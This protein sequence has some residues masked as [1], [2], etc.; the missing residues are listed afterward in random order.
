MK[1][2]QSEEKLSGV[3]VS[4]DQLSA[5]VQALHIEVLK[6]ENQ[7]EQF[8]MKR[9]T[10]E[11]VI[12]ELKFRD[13][14][15]ENEILELN[16][17]VERLTQNIKEGTL[18][19]EKTEGRISGIKSKLDLKTQVKENTFQDVEQLQNKIR[20][21]QKSRELLLEEMKEAEQKLMEN[22]QKNLLI[23]NRIRELYGVEIPK[24]LDVKLTEIDL[25]EKIQKT[26]RSIEN[27]GAVNMAVQSDYDE[28]INR[29]KLLERQRSDIIQS[30]ENLRETIQRI[31]KIA[32]E[33]FLNTFEQIN[34]NFSKLFTLF[35]EGGEGKLELIGD[36][37]PLEA[38]IAIRA[39]PPGKRNQNLR[40]LSAGE[41]SLT[42][43]ALLFAIYQYKPSPYCILDEVDAPLDDVNIRKFTRVLR[44]FSD[45]T[46]FIVVTHNKLTMEAANFLY[47]VTMEQKGVS[48]LVSV[49]FEA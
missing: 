48:K 42:A 45:E 21:E 41:K 5:E 6:L 2:S 30:E 36:P 4:R 38:D 15:I 12:D 34:T 19:I 26:N 11:K 46:Q 7:R 32:R 40:M 35:F 17:K 13:L 20:T 27:I 24:Y 33:I 18:S 16:E 43:I 14:E 37:D 44:Q 47:G 31:D 39:Q 3:R 8:R 28:E 9:N 23:I 29:L 1:L 49:K 22:K 10:T 25:Q